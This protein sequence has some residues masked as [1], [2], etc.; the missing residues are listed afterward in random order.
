MYS[1]EA[2]LELGEYNVYSIHSSTNYILKLNLTNAVYPR[3]DYLLMNGKVL[4]TS[5]G[6]SKLRLECKFQNY[7]KI[8]WYFNETLK[9]SSL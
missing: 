6:E 7:D 2:T 4:Q 9:N 8:E 1:C 3:L 5:A